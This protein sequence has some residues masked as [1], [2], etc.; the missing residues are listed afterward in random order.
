[1]EDGGE[2]RSHLK[3]RLSEGAPGG[4]ILRASRPGS[5]RPFVVLK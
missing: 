4:W 1:M 5:P 2:T 3:T